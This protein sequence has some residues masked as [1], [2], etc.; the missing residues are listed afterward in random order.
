M[1]T[2]LSCPDPQHPAFAAFNTDLTT[3]DIA[4]FFLVGQSRAIANLSIGQITLD[5]I[6]VNVSTSLQGLQG[7]K[8][9]T[10]IENVD[11]TGGT[12]TGRY[13]SLH[14]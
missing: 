13:Q 3:Q 14:F 7:L 1:A 2:N 11:V 10:T 9:M 4:N 6:K 12:Q 5:P 8:G